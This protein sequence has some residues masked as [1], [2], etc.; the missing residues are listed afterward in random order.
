MPM[1]QTAKRSALAAA[2]ALVLSATALTGAAEAKPKNF[3]L[4][5]GGNGFGVEIGHGYGRPYGYRRCGWL[6]RRARITGSPYWWRRYRRCM[7]R[8]YW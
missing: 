6:R 7:W 1:F 3:H 2:G 4:H 8:H 5:I